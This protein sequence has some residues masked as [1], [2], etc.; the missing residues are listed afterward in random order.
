[1]TE[2]EKD[3]KPWSRQHPVLSAI[4]ILLFESMLLASGIVSILYLFAR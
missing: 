3:I 1:M 4:L 2:L